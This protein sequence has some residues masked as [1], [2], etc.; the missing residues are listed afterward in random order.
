MNNKTKAILKEAIK[1]VII[2]AGALLGGAFIAP[3]AKE[4]GALMFDDNED[5]E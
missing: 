5:E 4:A 2:A 3:I 1:G